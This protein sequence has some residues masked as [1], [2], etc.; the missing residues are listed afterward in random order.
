MACLPQFLF[1]SASGPSKKQAGKKKSEERKQAP[2][3]NAENLGFP[4]WEFKITRSCHHGSAVTNPHS[5]REDAGSIPGLAQW[6]KDPA[7]SR[8]VV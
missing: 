4:D 1:P 8:A 5:M 7:L 2:E 3:P 6:V